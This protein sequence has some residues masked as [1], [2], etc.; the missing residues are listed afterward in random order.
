MCRYCG[1][2]IIPD[3]IPD[4]FRHINDQGTP[5]GWLCPPPHMTL[6]RPLP[7]QAG[8]AVPPPTQPAPVNLPQPP[9]DQVAASHTS[10][11]MAQPAVPAEPPTRRTTPI[12]VRK[13][14]P[15]APADWPPQLG[16]TAWWESP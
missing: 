16:D 4:L 6:A 11:A 5:T 7:A 15:D 9:P 13:Q 8:P 3:E 12:P 10:L 2:R 1:V 14:R